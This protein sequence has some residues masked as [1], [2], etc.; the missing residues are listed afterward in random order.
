MKSSTIKATYSLD[1]LTASEIE[2]LAKAWKVPKSEVVRRSIH[3]AVRRKEELAPRR[4]S[5][6]EALK[7]FQ[8]EPRLSPSDADKWIEEIRAERL[9]R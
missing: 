2:S 5:K 9:A 6:E 3:A 8:S 7:L 4:L 1:P